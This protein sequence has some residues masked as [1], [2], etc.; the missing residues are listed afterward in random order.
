MLSRVMDVMT[1]MG[2]STRREAF[3]VFVADAEPRLRRALC[4]LRGPV[5]GRDAVAEALAWGWENWDR[6]SEMENPVGYLYRVG[7]SRTRT[8]RLEAVPMSD[9]P[10]GPSSVTV[11]ASRFE[12]GLSPALARLS[13]RQRTAV[14]LVHGCGWSYQEVAT[15]LDLSKSAVGTHVARALEQLR[16]DLGVER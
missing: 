2:A 10:N 8:G 11:V 12:P 15:A 7:T 14:V 16:S 5:A 13:E 6:L 4:G 3:A 9:V 1:T